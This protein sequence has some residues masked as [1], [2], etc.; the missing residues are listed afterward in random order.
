MIAEAIPKGAAI[1]FKKRKSK[2]ILKNKSA[3]N[4][5]PK[6]KSNQS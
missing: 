3:I 5:H 2:L 4:F 1:L 6:Q